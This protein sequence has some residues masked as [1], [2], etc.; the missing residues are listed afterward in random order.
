M[1]TKQNETTVKGW[2]GGFSES[3]PDFNYPTPDLSS[4]P[5]PDNLQN[6][7]KLQRQ[8]KIKWPEFS[9]ETKPGEKDTERCYTMFSPEISRVGYTDT[10][11]S[12]IHI[13]EPTR[14]Y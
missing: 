2:K 11:L 14:P 7:N 6:I 9:W 4:L 5:L 1:K 12:L 13:S 3:N 10:G 8:M